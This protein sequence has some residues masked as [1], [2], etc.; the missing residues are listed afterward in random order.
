MKKRVKKELT[1]EQNLDFFFSQLQALLLAEIR[2]EF[3]LICSNRN[4]FYPFTKQEWQK[5]LSKAIEQHELVIRI[6]NRDRGWFPQ[7]CLL[8]RT[9]FYFTEKNGNNLQILTSNYI[10]DYPLSA[11]YMSPF[12]S[13]WSL[14]V[15]SSDLSNLLSFIKLQFA[16]ESLPH[17][18]TGSFK[19]AASFVVFQTLIGALDSSQEFP[20]TKFQIY[21]LNYRH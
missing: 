9:S 20:K 15:L 13:Q 6:L 1:K 5:F 19:L 12:C 3:S 11:T 16:R 18:F 14:L 10:S 8:F 7:V 4:I 17:F 2:K 21:G